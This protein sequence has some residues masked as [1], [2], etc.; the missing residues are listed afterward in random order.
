MKVA[1]VVVVGVGW[2]FGGGRDVFLDGIFWADLGKRMIRV[3]ADEVP[4]TKTT[5]QASYP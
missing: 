3:L 2:V 4:Q 1:I 5:F